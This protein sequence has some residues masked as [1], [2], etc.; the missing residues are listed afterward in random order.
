[1]F[2]LLTVAAVAGVAWS[3]SRKL[4]LVLA[5]RRD[6]ELGRWG[7]RLRGVFV[8]FVGQKRMFLEPIPGIMHALI[9]WGFLVF[10]VR[11]LSMVV[12]GLTQGWELPLLH[13]TLGHSYLLSKDLFAVLV[14]VGVAIATWRRLVTR[15]E[16][17]EYSADAWIILGLIAALMVTDLLADGARIGGG[18]PGPWAWTPVSSMVGASLAGAS[19]ASLRATY[20]GAWWLHLAV[21]YVF[22]NYLPYSKHFHV[23]TSLPNVLLRPLDEP[24]RL[25]KMDLENLQE[26]TVLGAAKVTDLTWKQLLDLYTCTECGRC[27][28]VCPTTITKKPL[29]PRDLTIDL[30]DHLNASSREILRNPGE[31]SGVSSRELAGDVIDPE[32]FWACTTCRWCEESC[33]LFIS[34]VDKIVEVRRHLVLEKAEFP[35]EAEP[36]FRG[37]EVNGNPWQLAAEARGDWA[38]G[39][40]VPLASEAGV[41]EVLFWVGCAGSYDDAGKRTSVALVKLLRAAGVKF[42]ILGPEERCTG[43]AARRLGNEYLF[44][45]LAGGNV[46]TLNRYGVK[47]I[48]TNCPH[49]FNTLA[50][51][52]PDFGG[53][54]DVLHGT[55]LVAELV[56]KGRLSLTTEMRRE[57]TYHDPCYLGRTNGQYDAPRA[58]LKAIPGLSLREAP[59]TREKAMCCGAGGGRM[60]L[61]EKLGTRINQTRLRQLAES[62][63]SDVAVACPFCAVMVGNAQQELGLETAQ[64]VDV[65]TLAAQALGKGS[66]RPTADS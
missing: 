10:T 64:T 47:R 62:G 40:D 58:V 61:E 46:E 59:L 33:P 66:Q 28:V 57:L 44:Q 2:A 4:S 63:A 7:E 55:Q 56:A 36:A 16:R 42:A 3:L 43:D 49:C 35:A 12:E 29:V 31:K 60:W 24:G 41:F 30:R 50:H 20:T 13:T 14:L 53:D 51:E 22:A 17:L 19:E 52:Y 11:S 32:V 26:G 8:F 45:T 15:P 27:T 54:Y 5:G 34:Y 39:L 6:V 21:L 48:V 23:Y 1:W 37:M 18:A 65:I 9:F 38:K 25:S